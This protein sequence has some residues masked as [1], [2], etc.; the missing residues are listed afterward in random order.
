VWC[1]QVCGCYDEYSTEF[2]IEVTKLLEEHYAVLEP[3]LCRSLVQSLILL[4]NRGQVSGG[5]PFST[6]HLE[7]HIADEGGPHLGNRGICGVMR[8]KKGR[9]DYLETAPSR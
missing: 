5:G 8:A 2:H 4:R 7:W 6:H 1:A 9:L 3:A